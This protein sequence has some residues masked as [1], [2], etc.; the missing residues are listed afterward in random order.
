MPAY[1]MR[2]LQEATRLA[3]EADTKYRERLA[4]ALARSEKRGRQAMARDV[5][6]AFA[7]EVIY[8][9][10]VWKLL[11]SELEAE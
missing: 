3:R 5:V 10:D 4:K 8:Q 2:H 1:E 7:P 11:R 9:D 6:E